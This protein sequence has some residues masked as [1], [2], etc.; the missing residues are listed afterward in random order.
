MQ[1]VTDIHWLNVLETM[2][3]ELNEIIVL[4]KEI[5]QLLRANNPSLLSN[6]GPTKTKAANR[7]KMS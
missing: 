7:P 3:K 4:L 6:Q 2:N 1:V 5:R